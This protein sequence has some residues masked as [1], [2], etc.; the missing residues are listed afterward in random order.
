METNRKK[1]F[2]TRELTRN[3][4]VLISL[5][6]IA[7][8]FWVAYRFIYTP[9]QEKISLLDAQRID[10]E[11]QIEDIN[12]T[13]KKENFINEEWQ[14]L[15]RE[16]EEIV[17]QYFPTLDQPQIIYI[18]NELIEND[19]MA[20]PDLNFSRPGFTDVG[21]LQVNSMDISF[22]YTGGYTGVVDTLNAI[23]TSPRKMLIDNISMDRDMNEDL[24]GMMSLKIYSLEG[25]AESDE[26]VVYIET[27]N[28]EDNDSPFGAY[29]GYVAG[30]TGEGGQTG[31]PGGGGLPGT[32]GQYPDMKPYIE[33]TLTDFEIN[34][35]YFIPSHEYVKGK[36]SLSNLS[37]SKKYSLKLE[38][39]IV[40]IE[41]ENMAFVDLTRNNIVIKYPPNTIGMWVY[42]YDYSPVTLGIRFKDQMGEDVLLPLAEGIGWTGWKYI[43]GTPA[44]DMNIYPMELESI[45]LQV[46]ENREDFGILLIDKLG[47]VYNRNLGEDGSDYSVSTHIFHIVRR[48]DTVESLSKLY[49]GTDKYENEIMNLNEIGAGDVL[50]PGKILVLKKRYYLP[51]TYPGIFK[52]ETNTS[53]SITNPVSES[54]EQK[55]STLVKDIP[56]LSP[57][58]S[59]EHVVKKGDSL[60]AISR[61]YYGSDSYVEEIMRLNGI[62]EGDLILVGEVLV[63][64][65]R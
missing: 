20:V 51:F 3:E 38:Y 65:K 28:N 12:T 37:K 60:Y 9:Q 48:G 30:G 8:L 52:G 32:N 57:E 18:L 6:V 61:E 22:P 56:K 26:E 59:M 41:E 2:K 1:R 13:L 25:I 19:E 63:L 16:K 5:L 40:A 29:E 47:A 43:E 4:K 33:E 58:E 10:Y 42:S 62:S 55:K 54:D 45:Y 17:S 11:G 31:S 23:K 53:E 27:A 36:V 46:P 49:Y 39:N 21:G 7:I 35:N 50:Q 64:K 14:E 44:T 15:N 34:N 24:N